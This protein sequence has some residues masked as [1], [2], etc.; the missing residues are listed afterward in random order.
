MEN[1]S[2]C[3]SAHIS[4]GGV[5]VGCISVL[6]MF[7]AKYKSLRTSTMIYSAFEKSMFVGIFLYNVC[8]NDLE[9]F[10]GWS[11][12]FALD[13]F[14]TIYSLVYTLLSQSR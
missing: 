13:A 1:K 9:W 6:L 14:V 3:W 5:M 2:T 12:V 11:G 7:S 10:Y 8:I 4:T